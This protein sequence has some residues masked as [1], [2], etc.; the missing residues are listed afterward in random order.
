MET[1]PWRVE[2]RNVGRSYFP[3]SRV[4]CHYS[5]GPQHHWASSDWIGLFKVGWASVRDYHTFVWSVSPEGYTEG[6]VANCC[7]HFQASYLPSPSDQLYQFVYVSRHG[8]V[9]AQSSPFAFCAPKPLEELVTLEEEEEEEGGG[10]SEGEDGCQMGGMLLVIPRAELL[11]GRLEDCLRERAELL[12]ARE[13]AERGRERERGR[14]EQETEEW[15][16]ERAELQGATAQL[17]AKLERAR[18]EMTLTQQGIASAQEAMKAEK[19]ALLDERDRNQQRIRELEDDI[20]A[21]SQRGLE[22][23]IEFDR[24]KERV[25]KMTLQQEQLLQQKREEEEER[26][27]LQSKLA[28]CEGELRGLGA[29]FQTLRGKLAERDTQALTLRDSV[30]SLTLRLSSAQQRQAESEAVCTEVGRLREQLSASKRRVEGLEGQLST[31]VGQRDRGQAE[32]HQARLEAAQL[33]LQ[34]TDA[35]LALREERGRWQEEREALQQIAQ[36]DREKLSRQREELG[37]LEERLQEERTERE[38][39]AVELGRERDCNRVQRG[40]AGRELQELRSGLKLA[41]R[42]REQLVQQQQELLRYVRQLEQRLEAVADAKWGDAASDSNSRPCSPVSESEEDSPE[43]LR[44]P[45][46]LGSYGLCDP[47]AIGA[48]ETLLLTTP[49][50]SPREPGRGGVVISQPAPLSSPRQ[51][52]TDTLPHSSESEDEDEEEEEESIQSAGHSSGDET[53]MLLPEHRHSE[54]GELSDA[55]LWQ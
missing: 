24:M 26:E 30:A 42:E 35:R 17:N 39:A 52:E 45:Q 5:L 3:Q 13:A 12:K 40:E 49:P 19:D 41:Q 37:R 2:F 21:I 51:Q 10:G 15:E 28:V 50:P 27:R 20:K 1:P 53:L 9:C 6:S 16:K 36:A 48:T 47:P 34:L 46:P 14:R 44:P 43:A 7:V 22:R 38:K 8:E 54:L 11:Q 18:E 32:L 55:P 4:D 31:T 29:E 25:K 33:T 23:E